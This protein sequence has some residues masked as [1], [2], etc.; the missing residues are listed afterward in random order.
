MNI[1][2]SFF[3]LMGA[4]GPHGAVEQDFSLRRISA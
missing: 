1:F 4:H 3:G 2:S